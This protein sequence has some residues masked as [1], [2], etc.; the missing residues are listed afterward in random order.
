MLKKEEQIRNIITAFS[1]V[2]TYVIMN[3]KQNLTDIN[4]HL[5][6]FVCSLLNKTFGYDL[7]NINDDKLNTAYIDL[8]DEKGKILIQVSSRHD[9]SKI[10]D[11][12][13]DTGHPG[14]K[15]RFFCI[16]EGFPNRNMKSAYAAASGI[17]FDPSE[18]LLD[19]TRL[20]SCLKASA[21]AVLDDVSRFVT[22]QVVYFY[23][24]PNPSEMAE[25][26][27]ELSM[28]LFSSPSQATFNHTA[29]SIMDKIKENDLCFQR[30]MTSKTRMP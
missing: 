1:V 19:F 20:V 9:K 7:H 5:E 30:F 6:D 14:F 28:T 22:T 2:K 23:F 18:D 26:V 10:N 21:D 24:R 25:V 12:L 4:I 16:G 13:S 15:Y 3:N 27:N 17:V 11:F 29:F 8:I